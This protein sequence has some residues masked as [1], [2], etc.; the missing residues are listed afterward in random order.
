MTGCTCFYHEET[1]TINIVVEM[2]PRH[3]KSLW[4]KIQDMAPRLGSQIAADGE[5]L[6]EGLSRK[7]RLEGMVELVLDANRPEEVGLMTKDEYQALLELSEGVANK[8]AA[9]SLAGYA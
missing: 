4:I 8:W 2:C 5:P 1:K 9:K 7:K 3:G 6:L